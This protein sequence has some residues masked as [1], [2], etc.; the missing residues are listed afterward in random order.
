VKYRF[1]EEHRPLAPVRV[2]CRALGVTKAGFMAWRNRPESH[3]RNQDRQ[4][5]ERIRRIHQDSGSVYGSPRIHQELQA[6]DLRVGRKRVARLMRELG[7]TA[8][9]PRRFVVTT[10]SDHDQPVAENLLDRDFT[11]TAPDQKW[12]TDIT[13]VPTD[14]GFL[15]LAAIE[16][17]FSRK[18]VGWAMDA[19]METSMVLRALDMA[20]TNRQP[21]ATLIHHSDR[22]SQY[23]SHDYR[24]RL[25][26][27]GIA[28]SMSRRGNC[29]DNACAES[30]WAR[31]KVE[32]VYRRRFRTREE[33]RHAIFQYIEVFYN[34]LRRHSALGYLS[35]DAFEAD[36]H[37]RQQAAS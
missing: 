16:D 3:R 6:Q 18:I 11:A 12:A 14:E 23:A 28:I 1:I 17:L 24:Q 29:Y 7:I 22:G 21:Q 34:R 37:R 20:M 4:V 25:L 32:L 15:Y 33:A 19:H 36:Y 13:Y 31:L 10:D 30:L 2:F 9:L 5:A 26:D 35:P 27:R 8:D